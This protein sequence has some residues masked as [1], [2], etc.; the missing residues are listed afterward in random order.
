MILH[1]WFIVALSFQDCL[2]KVYKLLT[3]EKKP[4]RFGHYDAKEVSD[5]FK[6]SS[7][8]KS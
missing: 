5:I 6:M 3:E 7:H 2:S 1:H 8:G 4:V